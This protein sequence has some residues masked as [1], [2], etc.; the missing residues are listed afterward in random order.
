MTGLELLEKYDK[1]AIVIKQFY[2]NAMLESLKDEE[3]PENFKEYARQTT[4]DNDKIGKLID[5]QPRGLFDVFDNNKVY[6]EMLVDYKKLDATFAYTVIDDDTMY[7]NPFHYNNR[8]E[9][10]KKA[11][12]QAF[13][14]LNNKL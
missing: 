10:E 1:A 9:A 8:K 3:L 11:V 4:I 5:V 6:I 14:I 7:S 2:L 13:E 12:E